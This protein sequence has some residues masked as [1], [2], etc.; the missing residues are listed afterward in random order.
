[1]QY[2]DPFVCGSVC[3]CT[4]HTTSHPLMRTHT[5]THTNPHTHTGIDIFILLIVSLPKNEKEKT[6]KKTDALTLTDVHI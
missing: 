3:M 4:Y 2:R 5:H 6:E 1:M